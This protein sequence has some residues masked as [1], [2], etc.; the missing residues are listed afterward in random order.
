MSDPDLL[1]RTEADDSIVQLREAILVAR[2]KAR[3]VRDSHLNLSAT[4]TL[5]TLLTL[6]SN[7]SLEFVA[8]P[9]LAPPEVQIDHALIAKY[10]EEL[11]QAAAAPLPDEV[12]PASMSSGRQS[13]TFDAG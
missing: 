12:S 6:G 3:W 2:P 1:L 4:F 8:A 9:A 13:L 11:K 5:S 7:Q 10:E